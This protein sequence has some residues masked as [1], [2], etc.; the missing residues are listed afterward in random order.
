[1]KLLQF[2]G[3]CDFI[4]KDDVFNKRN[5]IE[6]KLSFY[7]MYCLLYVLIIFIMLKNK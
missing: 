4:F 7:K 2:I 6:K 3:I 5:V 1:M